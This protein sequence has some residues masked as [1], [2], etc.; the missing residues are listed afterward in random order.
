MRRHVLLGATLAAMLLVAGAL[1]KLVSSEPNRCE[2][3]MTQDESSTQAQPPRNVLGQP[4]KPCC[5]DP[6]TGFY[7]DGSCRTGP[8]DRGSHVVCAIM[9]A[10]FL[11]FTRARGNDLETPA[12]AH[13]FPGLKPG[14][15][16]CL[17]ASRW[18]EAYAAGVAPLVELESTHQKALEFVPL[19]ALMSRAAPRGESD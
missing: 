17:C 4:L 6:L 10:E 7:R 19:E 2:A 1:P 13:H 3:P 5:M 9:T 16:W 12:P 8:A 14:D 15:R 11:R 18:R